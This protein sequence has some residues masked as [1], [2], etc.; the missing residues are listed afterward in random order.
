MVS[1]G[2]LV[3]T[4]VLLA[5]TVLAIFLYYRRLKVL[6][7]EYERA[8]GVVEDI[9]V[10]VDTQFRRQKDRV[11]YVAEKIEAASLENKKVVNRIEEYEGRLTNLTNTVRDVPQIEERVSGQL[12]AMRSE[13]EGIKE[14]QNKV[15][16]KLGEIEKI[17]QEP[18]VPEMK[19]EAAIPIK[20]EKALEPL[21]E[22]ELM[23]LETIG[24]EGEKTAP[25]IREKIGLTRE[26]TA[27]LMKKLYKDGYLE[28]D[29][30]KMPYVYRLKEEMQKILKRREAR[31]P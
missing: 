28:R 9:V 14:A 31:T 8:R 3:V 23:V 5:V 13:V 21:T 27:R 18:Y 17:K 16:Q 24:T 10:G 4:S 11:L 19:I 6:R 22:T 30:H 15:M 1:E 20:R 12:R 2:M 26:H 29:T 7:Y 25:D